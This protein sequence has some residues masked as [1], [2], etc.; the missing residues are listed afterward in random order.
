VLSRTESDVC[1][2]RVG[3]DVTK[4]LQSQRQSAKN[5]HELNRKGVGVAVHGKKV[6]LVTRIF[7]VLIATFCGAWVGVDVQRVFVYSVVAF[8]ASLFI[9]LVE[10]ATDFVSS[11]KILL[12]G[13]GLF[14][15]LAMSALVYPTIPHNVMD[16]TKARI[17]CNLL[18]G[19]FGIILALKHEERLSLSRLKFIIANPSVENASILDTNVIIDGRVADIYALNF[20]HGPL[21][22]PDFVLK[23][24]QLIADSTDPKKRAKGRRGLE[25]LERL[26]EVDPQLQVYEKDYPEVKD[27]D[28]KLI[29][30]A[31]EIN[32]RIITNDYNLNKVASIQRITVLNI[33]ELSQALK[34]PVS[35]GDEVS[36]SIIREGKESHQG[37]G[38]LE[39]GTMVVV[40]NGSNYVGRDVDVVVTSILQSETGRMVFGRLRDA[41]RA[42]RVHT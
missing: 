8:F 42:R 31:K 15:G 29:Q 33:N 9:I 2:K 28:T 30:L 10:Y 5:N 22:I 17:V 13:M 20:L 21:I 3:L 26:K 7:F 39:D 6:I 19:Y 24:L 16:E 35:I 32:G 25:H 23:E 12:A 4:Q 40:D 1:N 34:P 36:I 41:A 37:V 38:Y 11:K 18:F 14:V 27:V